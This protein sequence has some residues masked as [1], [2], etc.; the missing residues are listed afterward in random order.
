MKEGHTS[1][2]RSSD[3]QDLN[4]IARWCEEMFG[5]ITPQRLASR[6]QEEMDE[7]HEE[8]RKSNEWTTAAREEVADIIIILSRV[9]GLM[10]AVHR[11]MEKNKKRKWEFHGDGTGRHVPVEFIPSI[12]GYILIIKHEEERFVGCVAKVLDVT[13]TYPGWYC[14][15]NGGGVRTGEYVQATEAHEHLKLIR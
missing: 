10:E 13:P 14:R 15:F 6:A 9:P 3:E 2:D 4:G 12:G 8:L 7:L 11:K 1:Y 5:P